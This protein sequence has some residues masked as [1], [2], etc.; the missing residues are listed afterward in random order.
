MRAATVGVN[1][2]VSLGLAE[3]AELVVVLLGF[4][5]SVRIRGEVGPAAG[6]G[7]RRH[8]TRWAA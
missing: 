7:P 1:D 3:I 4:G 6:R 5:L 8:G 2:R